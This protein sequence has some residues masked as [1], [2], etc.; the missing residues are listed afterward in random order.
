M[1][2]A[3][4]VYKLLYIGAM[5]DTVNDSMILTFKLTIYKTSLSSCIIK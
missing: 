1:Y 3:T 4:P 5:E 2:C